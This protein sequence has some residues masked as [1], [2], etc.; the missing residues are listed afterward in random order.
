MKKT[1]QNTTSLIPYRQRK[2]VAN[3]DIT[4]FL[5]SPELYMASK[6]EGYV[7]PTFQRMKEGTIAHAE[8]LTPLKFWDTYYL[9]AETLHPKQKEFVDNL[10]AA[11][12]KTE[13]FTPAMVE[14][15]YANV[16]TKPKLGDG[17]VLFKK[18]EP[19]VKGLYQKKEPI[20]MA[21][22][23]NAEKRRDVL[24]KNEEAVKYLNSADFAEEEIY[25]ELNG[26]KCKAQIDKYGICEEKKELTILDLKILADPQTDQQV[27]DSIKKWDYLRQVRFYERGIKAEKTIREVYPDI[28]SYKVKRAIIAVDPVVA[29][30]IEISDET[31]ASRDA[32]ID[33]ALKGID[34]LEKTKSLPRN[35]TSI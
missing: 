6:H 4:N 20:T 17:M 13:K 16:Y 9:Q 31:A 3:S 10:V 32:I 11:Y 8:I 33:E 28:D 30:V 12:S 18:L 19:H 29:R 21:M 35:V 24:F 1:K 22:K 2:E 25:F 7:K 26:V 15:I 23:V 27:I 34:Q 5:I 14:D